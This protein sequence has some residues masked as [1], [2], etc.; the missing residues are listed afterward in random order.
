ML[1]LGQ[2]KRSFAK[3]EVMEW[4]LEV[5][6][7]FGFQTT[8]WQNGRIQKSLL[9]GFSTLVADLSEVVVTLAKLSANEEAEGAGL[10]LYS[11]NRFNN[12]RFNTNVKSAGPM[13]LTST[14]T[15]PYTVEVGQLIASDAIG[16]QFTNTTGGTLSA[17]GTLTLQWQALLAGSSGNVGNGSVNILVTPLAGVTISNPDS[18]SGR[19]YTTI[20][21]DE[22]LDRDLRE[23]NASKWTTL[24]L[25]WVEER[26]IYHARKL[27]ARKVFVDATNPRG[28]G[29]VDVYVSADYLVY[30]DE[31]M[32]EFQAGFAEAT[33]ETE[34]VWPPTDSPYP[35]HVYCKQPNEFILD[36]QGVIY[37]DPNFSQAAMQ[38]AVTLALNDFVTLLPIGGANY[39][40]G[41]TNV[42][43]LSDLLDAI[44][45]VRGVRAFT[46]ISPTGNVTIS[47]N[48]LVTPPLDGWFGSGLSLVAVTT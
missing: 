19:W 31:Q 18:G 9:S 26:Y 22:E 23:R 30:D 16:T 29:S 32:A 46:P 11:R 24:S 1:S 42:I 38:A 13:V 44:E 47:P 34:T 7:E 37:Y 39:A 10:T 36:L 14:A 48:A 35:S 5:L 12:E 6:T 40:P 21:L 2:A 20:G 3:S 43:A 33:F 4:C 15:V 45:N 25:E 17:S 27:G 41:P 8:G 28:P